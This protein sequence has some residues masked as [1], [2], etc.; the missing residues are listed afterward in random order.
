MAL[1]WGLVAAV[2]GGAL[3]HAL[4]NTLVKSSGDKELD[5]ALVHL[6]GAV[7]A[8]PMLAW[9]GLPPTQAWP[10]IAASLT[11]HVAYYITLAGA[12]RHG[13]LS[14]T[15]PIMR[16][17]AP[18]LV[19]LGSG[20]VLGEAL[21][22]Q[23]WFGVLAITA[24]VALVGLSHA[25]RLLRHRAAIGYAL[26]NAVVIATYTFIDGQ[27]VRVTV[28]AGHVVMSYVVILFVLDGI[29]YPALV[30]LRRGPAQRQAML[31]YA[32][33]R[34]LLAACGGLAS[35]GSYAV[36]LWAMTRA[37]VAVVAAL[38]ESSVLFATALSV[39]VLKERF[40][41]QRLAGALVIVAGVVTLRFA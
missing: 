11:V 5:T 28:A 18:L 9:T 22:A 34:G 38:R 26:A 30:W 27:G 16:G 4:W 21:S 31:A 17:T 6:L 7:V 33:Q 1:T 29:P 3:L 13:D 19:S 15:Y 40:G 2:L 23:A 35:L 39:W 41:P 36:A 8:L 25:G 14:L 32:R 20:L 37:P 24:G 12:Y 10:Y